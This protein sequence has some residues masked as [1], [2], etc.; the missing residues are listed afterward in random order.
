MKPTLLNACKLWQLWDRRIA[1]SAK[2]RVEYNTS[3]DA[4]NAFAKSL[5]WDGNIIT[6]NRF[7]ADYR[8]RAIEA[9]QKIEWTGNTAEWKGMTLRVAGTNSEW[10]WD[11]VEFDNHDEYQTEIASSNKRPLAKTRKQARAQAEAAA[12]EYSERSG[13]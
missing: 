12:R 10:C 1:A 7:V 11:V 9:D 5:G 6:I 2:S 8:D 3:V 13:K 4:F